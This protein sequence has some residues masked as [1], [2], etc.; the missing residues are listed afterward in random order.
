MFLL[1]ACAGAESP[2]LLQAALLV[3]QTTTN[4]MDRCLFRFAPSCQHPVFLSTKLHWQIS[5]VQI[6]DF[7]HWPYQRVLAQR[8]NAIARL[9]KS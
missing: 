3:F 1:H 7:G 6:C 9:L 2:Y 8:T 5:S 4:Q